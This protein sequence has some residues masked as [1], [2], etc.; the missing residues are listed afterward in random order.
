MRV[1]DLGRVRGGT[2]A[3]TLE[4]RPDIPN[5][6]SGGKGQSGKSVARTDDASMT[7]A[8]ERPETSYGNFRE[9]G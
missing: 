8:P 7:S 4:R 9:C 1:A 6:L 5:G 3:R 2:P